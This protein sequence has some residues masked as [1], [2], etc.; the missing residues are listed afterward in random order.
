MLPIL[1]GTVASSEAS[2]QTFELIQTTVLG[3]AAASITFSSLDLYPQYK[4]LQLRVVARTSRASVNSGAQAWIQFNGDTSASYARHQLWN[5]DNTV[6]SGGIA[7]SNFAAYARLTT[8]RDAWMGSAI[9][10]ILDFSNPNKN[11]TTRSMTG[12]LGSE[13]TR[14]GLVSGLWANTAAVTSITL[15]AEQG[16]YEVNSRFSLYGVK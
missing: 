5:T 14:V 1:L 9:V 12:M 11:T 2:S 15:T 3:T 13:E 10:D 8:L 16:N 6:T 4:H 7:S